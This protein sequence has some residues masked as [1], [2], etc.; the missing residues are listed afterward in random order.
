MTQDRTMIPASALDGDDCALIAQILADARHALPGSARAVIAKL[1]LLEREHA[2]AA[3][4]YAR[5]VDQDLG[6]QIVPAGGLE[7][8]ELVLVGAGTAEFRRM[9]VTGVELMVDG[10]PTWENISGTNA[11]FVV[12]TQEV[13]RNAG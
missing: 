9:T 3:K 7:R 11:P 5:A 13:D 2:R 12:V 4:L 10:F 6:P 8:G 1:R